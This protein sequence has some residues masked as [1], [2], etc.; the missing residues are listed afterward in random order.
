METYKI[1]ITY[2]VETNNPNDSG[3]RSEVVRLSD[4]SEDDAIDNLVDSWFCPVE[5]AEVVK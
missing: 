1:K 5:S 4:E 3:L 2:R